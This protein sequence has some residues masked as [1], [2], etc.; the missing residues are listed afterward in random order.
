MCMAFQG[1]AKLPENSKFIAD[2]YSAYPLSS[3]EFGKK[4]GKGFTF[5][6]TQVIGLTNDD[7]VSMEHR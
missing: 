1:L 5:W 6:I 3:M 7:A 2:G 4:F